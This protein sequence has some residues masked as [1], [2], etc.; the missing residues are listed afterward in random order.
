MRRK[1]DYTDYLRDMLDVAHKA[2]RFIAGVEFEASQ[3]N[4]TLRDM[5]PQKFPT[6]CIPLSP[7]YSQVRASVSLE[8]AH[9]PE[10]QKLCPKFFSSSLMICS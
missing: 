7:L 10:R 4:S 8:L 5:L 2:E 6:T 9:L 3:A 1:R